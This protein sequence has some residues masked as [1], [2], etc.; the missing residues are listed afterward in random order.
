MAGGETVL[1]VDDEPLVRRL[2]AAAL[3]RDGFAVLEADGAEEALEISRRHPGRIDLVLTD[4]C[5]P[6]MAG[7]EL[8]PLLVARRPGLRALYMSG[9][10]RDVPR[11]QVTPL[12]EKPFTLAALAAAVRGAL[13]ESQAA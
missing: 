3:E 1:V 7:S 10:I 5:M 8:V 12:L 11:A 2:V 6:R 4:V 9:D 13:H